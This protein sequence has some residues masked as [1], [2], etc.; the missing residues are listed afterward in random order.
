MLESCPNIVRH[1]RRRPLVS[2]I[3]VTVTVL[4]PIHARSP[5]P[6]LLVRLALESLC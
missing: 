3:T 6:V 2:A 5:L 1:D 4:A